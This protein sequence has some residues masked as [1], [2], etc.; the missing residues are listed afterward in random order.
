MAGPVGRHHVPDRRVAAVAVPPYRA[1]GGQ[2]MS[3]RIGWPGVIRQAG[4]IA[5]RR[6]DTTC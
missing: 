6:A 4:E 1:G 5:G 2:E 3:A